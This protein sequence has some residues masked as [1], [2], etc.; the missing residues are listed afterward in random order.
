MFVVSTVFENEKRSVN[1]H[2]VR[3]PGIN[4]KATDLTG[5]DLYRAML[6]LKV[7]N[8]NTSMGWQ[9]LAFRLGVF[10]QRQDEQPKPV[11]KAAV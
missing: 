9:D 2:E 5:P 1:L 4:V 3:V 6:R 11:A 7:P 10:I 8:I